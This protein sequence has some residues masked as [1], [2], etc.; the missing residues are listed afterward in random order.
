MVHEQGKEYIEVIHDQIEESGS[1]R[2]GYFAVVVSLGFPVEILEGFVK[3]NPEAPVS[4]PFILAVVRIGRIC[5]AMRAGAQAAGLT[6]FGQFGLDLVHGQ[7]HDLVQTP[8]AKRLLTGIF[9]GNDKVVCFQKIPESFFFVEESIQCRRYRGGSRPADVAEVVGRL[10][11]FLVIFEI[12][13]DERHQ[14][15][16]VF[17][18][19]VFFK[20]FS[21]VVNQ[22]ALVRIV[23]AHHEAQDLVNQLV[24]A[25]Q[26][27]E[28]VHPFF[29][30]LIAFTAAFIA[31][32]FI[33]AADV[34][35]RT[36]EGIHQD[37]HLS[38]EFGQRAAR[39]LFQIIHQRVDDILKCLP[40][41]YGVFG[42]DG[43]F[44]SGQ[45]CVALSAGRSHLEFEEIHD[46][47][48]QRPQQGMAGNSIG[49]CNKIGIRV[50][51]FADQVIDDMLHHRVQEDGQ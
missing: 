31:A 6:F 27:S 13:V 45:T 19:H 38:Q 20:N 18:I 33:T 50:G 46:L 1:L 3:D 47:G 21:Q 43:A 37:I 10:W 36:H 39:I 32:I 44:L 9:V 12:F 23:I 51:K 7:I 35:G 4:R 15:V 41:I 34:D 42:V 2:I 48:H 8:Q 14:A 22:R 16:F 29:L 40:G 28:D 24:D 5:P 26:Q 17:F 25:Q 30:A 11:V 49:I